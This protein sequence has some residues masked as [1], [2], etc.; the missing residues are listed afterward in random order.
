MRPFTVC[1]DV[2][3]RHSLFGAA[4]LTENTDPDMYKYSGYG[5]GFD[6]VV[7]VFCCLMVVALVKT[8]RYLV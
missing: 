3:L 5:I 8:L 6:D 7:E 2:K 1:Q 4:K